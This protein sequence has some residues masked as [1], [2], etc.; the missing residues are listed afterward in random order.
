MKATYKS[1]LLITLPLTTLGCLTFLGSATAQITPDTSLGA[2]SSVV[3]PNVEIRDIPSDRIDG[4]AV[5]GNNLFHSFSDFN[6]NSGRGAYFS[7]PSGIAN[8][9]SRVTGGNASNIGGTL[10]VLGNAN[11]FFANPNGVIFG[12]NARLDV[13]G[14]FFAS[15]ADSFIFDNGFE[16]NAS[17]PQAPPLLTVNIPV[18]LRFRENPGN[19]SNAGNLAV[20]SGQNLTL[21]GKTITSN[22]SLTAPGGIIQ[23]LGER[24]GLLDNASIDVSG[25]TNGGN[26]FIGGNFQGKGPLPN[27]KR[28]YIGP[29]VNIKADAVTNGDGGRVIVWADE[30]TGFYGNISAKGGNVFG[31]GGFVEVSGKKQLIFR[32]NVDTSAIRGFPGVLLLDPTNITI[33]DG[34]GDSGS[35]GTDTFAGNNSGVA[36]SILSTPLSEINDTAP[37][38]IYKSELEGL[39][40]DTNVF[41]QATN[42]ITVNDLSGTL[43]FPAGNGLIAFTA[44]AD[45]NGV[46]DFIMNDSIDSNGRDISISGANLFLGSIRT[47]PDYYGSSVINTDPKID[48]GAITLTASGNISAN[49]LQSYSTWGGNGGNGGAITLTAGGNISLDYVDSFSADV[50]NT[51]NG[52]AIT[53]TAING[54]ISTQ[55]LSSYTSGENSAGNGGAITLTAKNGNISTGYLRTGSFSFGNTGNGGAITLTAGGNIFVEYDNGN[56]AYL[57]SDSSSSDGGDTGNGGDIK[58]TAINGNIFI[59]EVSANSFAS[60]NSSSTP[61]PT[62][63]LDAGNTGNGGAITLTAKNGNISTSGIDSYAFST[64]V[65]GNSGNAGHGGEIR[66]IAGSNISTGDINSF[67]YSTTSSAGNGGA[68]TL[69]SKNG[70]I[71]GISSPTFTSSS[72][73]ENGIARNGGKVILEAQGNVTDIEILT[74]SS[75]SNSGAVQLTGVRDLSVTNTSIVTSKQLTVTEPG[76]KGRTFTLNIG[77]EGQSG[78]VTVTSN[79]NLTFNNSSIESDTK[80]SD[81]AGNVNITSPGLITF[82]NSKIVSDSNSIG[83]AGSIIVSA[84]REITFTDSNSG[85][86]AQANAEGKAGNIEVTTPTLTLLDTARI[87]ATATETAT[88]K[89]QGGSIS[90]NAS[91]MDL[92]GIVGVFAETQGESPAGTLT[93]QPDNNKPTLDLTLAPGSK[94]SASTSGS[95]KGGDLLVN[96]PQAINISGSGELAVETEGVGNAGKIEINTQKLTLNDGVKISASTKESS[97]TGGDLIINASEST[98]LKNQSSLLS[99]SKGTGVAG[100]LT[101]NTP[102]LTLDNKAFISAETASAQGGD[103]NINL[104]DLLLMRGESLISATAGTEG[105]GG[106][107][108]NITING[109][110]AFIVGFPKENSDIIANAFNGN[111]GKINIDVYNVFGFVERSRAELA[112]LSS[113]LDPRD[114]PTNDITAISQKNPEVDKQGEVNVN[115]LQEFQPTEVPEVTVIDPRRQIAQNPCQQG[116][117]SEFVVTGRGGLPPSPTQTTRSETVRV[118]LVKPA[119][120]QSRGNS[121]KDRI[122]SSREEKQT[123]SSSSAT[124][125]IV[126]AQGWVFKHNGEVVLTAHNS[127]NTVTLRSRRTPGICSGR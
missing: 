52:G 54:N 48:G 126:P 9:L 24:V 104:N 63:K 106:D 95:G 89:E 39:S 84:D 127:N 4:G 27:A 70:D 124:K 121:Q 93:L 110:N 108:G 34:T 8:I 50:E 13:S 90:L 112:K 98:L 119:P 21:S 114:L 118:D 19:I 7:N 81:P 115:T 3:T 88:S 86:F 74:Q 66:L 32:G 15:T 2:E 111:G 97:G 62:I 46:G 22:G 23:V 49:E 100:N 87:T 12:P 53:L 59:G 116:V 73:S 65:N 42:D 107:G 69:S 96:A 28:T 16:F 99:E 20:T 29:N 41:L 82:N 64:A 18:G 67:S 31:N 122:R 14:S 55:G 56:P 10:G 44:D 61:D 6:I 35:D 58:L 101:I 1:L 77:E 102:L 38:T 71:V 33:A 30:V 68:I 91:K 92:A 75:G 120:Q 47:N 79:G 117:G 125:Q 26:V 11:L 94:I 85:I 37:T 40:G 5:R 83:D 60:P 45:G 72:L 80:G 123:T 78:N 51:L 17:N 105:A 43:N 25:D 109:R 36:G 103:I 57:D 113:R 76:G